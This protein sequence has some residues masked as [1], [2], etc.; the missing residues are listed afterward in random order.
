MHIWCVCVRKRHDRVCAVVSVRVNTAI[1]LLV[2]SLIVCILVS[3]VYVFLTLT[4]D[5]IRLRSLGML[6]D[7]HLQHFTVTTSH[8]NYSYYSKEQKGQMFSTCQ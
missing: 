8:Y 4:S 3:E 7:I 1:F 2:D 5:K 6:Y